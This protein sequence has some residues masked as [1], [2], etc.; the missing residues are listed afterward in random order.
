MIIRIPVNKEYKYYYLIYIIIN[1]YT[2][3]QNS[4]YEKRKK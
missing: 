2:S 4:K 1:E 3:V